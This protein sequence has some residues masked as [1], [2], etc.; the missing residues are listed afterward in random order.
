MK[1]FALLFRQGTRKLSP[2]EQKQRGEKVAAWAIDLS[3]KEVLTFSRLLGED[4]RQTSANEKNAP[5]AAFTLVR[6]ENLEEAF[7]LAKTF[8]GIEYGVSVEVRE[9]T[10]PG[11]PKE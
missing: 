1:E 8:P 6:A 11:P 10:Q 2:E 9:A 5:V 3:N 7:N 4:I